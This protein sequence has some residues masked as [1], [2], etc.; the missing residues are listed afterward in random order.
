MGKT[1]LILKHLLEKWR[2]TSVPVYVDLLYYSS[3]SDFAAGL[4]KSFLENYDAVDGANVS[5]F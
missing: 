1:H 2:K 4:T 3:W 5:L